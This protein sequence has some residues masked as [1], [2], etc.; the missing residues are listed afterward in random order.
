MKPATKLLLICLAAL[1]LRLVLLI[2]VQHPGISDPNHYYNV[3][4]N[5]VNGRGYTVN[6]IWQYNHPPESVVHPDDYFMPLTSVVAAASMALFGQTVHGALG[7]FILIGSLLPIIGYLAARQFGCAEDGCLFAAASVAFVPELV[8]NSVRSDTTIVNALLVGSTILLLNVGLQR[9]KVWAFALCGLTAGL[10]YMTRSDSSLLM[11]ML[12][13]T[14]IV[15]ALVRRRDAGRQIRWRYAALVPIVAVLVAVP[16]SLRNLNY[17]GSISTPKVDEMFFLVD[18][19]DHYHYAGVFDLQSLLQ[20]QTIPQIIGK[21][22][23]EMAASLKLMYTTLDVFLPIAVAGGLIL[24]I[25]ARDRKRGLILAPALILMLGYFV[26]YSV[27][28]PLKSQGGSFKKDDLTL[29]PLF[30]PLAAYALE[31]VIP[32]RRLRAGTMVLATVFL[33]LNAFEYVRADANFVSGYL[34]RNQAMAAVAHTLPDMN[35]DGQLILM[36]QDPFMLDFLGLHSAIFPSDDRDIVYA[37]A[38]R[39]KVDYLL[40]PPDRP[41]LDA[42]YLRT[43][44]DPRFVHV[45]DVPGTEYQFFK[46]T[47][48]SGS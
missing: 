2:F 23:F 33:A 13:V 32:D 14:L 46:V 31:R 11:P 35:G 19:R 37:V 15:Y 20:R 42:L 6:Y 3:G 34:G 44:T 12:V 28:A 8:L 9:G 18:Y 25:A 36:S 24:L 41:A 26:F 39:Y 43:D 40:M 16:W 30:V 27:L 7:L 1:A 38:Q 17:S 22:L 21:R 5:L 10:A 48:E 29:I 45:A 4:L 47:P